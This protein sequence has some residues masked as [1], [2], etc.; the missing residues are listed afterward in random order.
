[1]KMSLSKVPPAE[2]ALLSPSERG[3]YKQQR[4][5]GMGRQDIVHAWIGGSVPKQKFTKLKTKF[6]SYLCA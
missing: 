5:L 2:L 6:G 1:M 4:T 3:S